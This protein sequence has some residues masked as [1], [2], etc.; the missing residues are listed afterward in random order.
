MYLVLMVIT[1]EITLTDYIRWFSDNHAVKS[2][3]SDWNGV[4]IATIGDS[5]LI[6]LGEVKE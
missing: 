6:R 5:F 2:L 1:M 3:D 4:V